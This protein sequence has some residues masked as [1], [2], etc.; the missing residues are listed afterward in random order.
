[1]HLGGDPTGL[2]AVQPCRAPRRRQG[3]AI[4][5]GLVAAVAA[6]AVL[7]GC[8]GTSPSQVAIAAGARFCNNSGFYIQSKLTG[9]KSVIYDCRFAGKLPACVT[10]SG[11]IASDA[12]ATVQLLFANSLDGRKPACLSWLSAAK[13]RQAAASEA[14][15]QKAYQQALSADVHAA[16]HAG[17]TADYSNVAPYELPNI[18]YKFLKPPF[19]CAQYAVNGCYKLEVVT[20]NGCPT[21]LSVQLDE[22]SNDTQVGTLYGASGALGPQEHAVIEIDAAQ[23]QALQSRIG[24]ILC[25]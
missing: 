14:A 22:E 2:G 20:R 11:S 4:V 6:A 21:A 3:R 16:W 17:Y 7:A 23:S 12:T 24:S 1:M 19:S 8:G 15:S 13:A 18:Y 9:N 10:Y 25:N 5:G